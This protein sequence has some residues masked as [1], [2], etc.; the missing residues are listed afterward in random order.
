MNF[1]ITAEQAKKDYAK[2]LVLEK[3]DENYITQI[4]ADTDDSCGYLPNS[5][6]VMVF[7]VKSGQMCAIVERVNKK[8]FSIFGRLKLLIHGKT[9]TRHTDIGVEG[10]VYDRG[11][12]IE[13]QFYRRWWYDIAKNV[14]LLSIASNADNNSSR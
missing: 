4:Y 5:D 1:E 6:V 11:E 8:D 12:Y 7:E 3:E 2:W 14:G 13:Y 9:I 10:F